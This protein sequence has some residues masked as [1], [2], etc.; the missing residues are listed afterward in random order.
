MLDNI[1]L[2]EHAKKALNENWGY[3]WGTFGQVLTYNLFQQKLN[4]YPIAVGKYKNFIKQNY[5]NK[6][7]VDCVGLIKSYIWNNNGKIIYNSQYDVSADG[8]Y[9]KAI[10]K[11]NIENIPE[12]KGLCV[13]K[14]GH[15]GVYIGNGHVIEAH[16]TKYGVIQTPLKGDRATKWTHWLKCPYIEYIHVI[17]ENWKDII[18]HVASNP[19]EWE[20]AINV[21]VKAA[22]AEG[23][24][25]SLEIFK[26]LPE[27]IEKVY[28]KNKKEG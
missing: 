16:G 27:L 1:G 14:K 26:F 4:Q 25:G 18:K 24:L 23:D 11:D 7:T 8:M 10:E 13:W 6:R 21:A 2:V 22:E 19:M 3:V 17:D 5:I 28:I 15:I 9:S 12:I 20:K